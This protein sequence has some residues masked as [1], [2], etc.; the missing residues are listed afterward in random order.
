MLLPIL[1]CRG[2]MVLAARFRTISDQI[3]QKTRFTPKLKVREYSA[4][5]S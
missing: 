5:E 2:V 4:A 1:T 3:V